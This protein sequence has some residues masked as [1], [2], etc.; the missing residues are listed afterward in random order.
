MFVCA[1]FIDVAKA[2]DSVNHNILLNKLYR[3]GFCG[4]FHA[5]LKSF[6]INRT[7]IVSVGN[8]RS[9]L[10]FLTSE[11]PQGSIL[12]PLFFNIYVNDISTSITTSK[13]FQYADDTLIF[14]R[15]LVYERAIEMLQ[16]DVAKIMDWFFANKLRV[17]CFKKRSWSDFT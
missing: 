12:S 14:S 10:A 16:I 15:H 7:Q 11:V 17:K 3:V 8:V 9:S 6:L 5:L 13:I 4:P 1:L 2:F